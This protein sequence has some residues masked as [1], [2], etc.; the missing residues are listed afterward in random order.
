MLRPHTGDRAPDSAEDI[1]E[2]EEGWQ[3]ADSIS[4]ELG[5]AVRE[6]LDATRLIACGKDDASRPV[7]GFPRMPALVTSVLHSP[8]LGC[9]GGGLVS[10]PR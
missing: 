2:V 5:T 3:P 4:R 10:T 9:F 8:N 6:V 1:L 7:Y